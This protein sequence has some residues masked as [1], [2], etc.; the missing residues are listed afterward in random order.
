MVEN[1]KVITLCGSTGFKDAFMG[2]QK[3]DMTDEIYVINGGDYI[4]ESIRSQIDYSK[5]TGKRV[6]YLRRKRSICS[7]GRRW[8]S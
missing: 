2:A 8:I 6:N 3:L 5:D 1:Y 4:N 7:V